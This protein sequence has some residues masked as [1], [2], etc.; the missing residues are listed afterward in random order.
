MRHL[1]KSCIGQHVRVGQV[2]AQILAGSQRFFKVP[3]ALVA[4][5][6]KKADNA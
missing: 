3:T 5:R 6:I 4:K 1:L 2:G